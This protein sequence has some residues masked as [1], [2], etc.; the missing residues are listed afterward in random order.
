MLLVDTYDTLEGVRHAV[1]AA[2]ATGVALA[3]VRLD[4]GDLLELSRA[5]RRMLDEAGMHETRI[6]A[7]GDLE[8][9]QITRLVSRRRAD[10]LL[11]RRHGPRHQP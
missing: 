8:E 10:R 3:G 11:G 6:F 5:A 4:S 7:S 2:R 9:R 1:A